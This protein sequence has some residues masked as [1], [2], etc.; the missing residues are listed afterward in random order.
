MSE[1]KTIG[2]IVAAGCGIALIVIVGIV[3]SKNA[4][5]AA[6]EK[7]IATLAAQLGE[8]VSKSDD[9]IRDRDFERAASTLQAIEPSIVTIGDYSLKGQYDQAMSRVA[10]AERDCKAKVKTGW[11]VFEGKFI[12]PDQTQRIVADRKRKQEEEIRRAEHE[13]KLAEVV[14]DE[15]QDTPGKS[16]VLL[17]VVVH[18]RPSKSAL[19][20]LLQSL[21]DKARQRG[22]FKFRQHPNAVYIYAYGPNAEPEGAVWIGMASYNENTGDSKPEIRISDSRLEAA[23][24]KASVKAGL[25]ERQRKQVFWESGS[26]ENREMAV[27]EKALLAGKRDEGVAEADRIT[28]S[29][30]R[31]LRR[32]YGLT[33]EELLKIKWEGATKGWPMP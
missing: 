29:G 3:L 21:F 1:N 19:R 9:Y 2:I 33:E 16:Q 4:K 28:A 30:E 8:S 11:A 27:L 10:S 13:R 17:K 6:R 12:S 20:A 5:A 25:S 22:G 26:I 15:R 32:K 23:F 31:E 14:A 24:E 18:E 7:E